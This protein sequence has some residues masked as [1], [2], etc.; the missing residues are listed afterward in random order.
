[1]APERGRQPWLLPVLLI[2]VIATAI[3]GLL[4][5]TVYEDREVADVVPAPSTSV[6]PEEQPGPTVVLGTQDAGAHPL[7][8]PVR[9]VL[10]TYFDAIN[11]RDYE[12]WTATVT[13][14][15]VD[16]QPREAWLRSY[17]STRDG[18]IVVHRIELAAEGEARVLMK[19]TSVQDPADAPQE[20]RVPC[21][22][23]NVVFPLVET[24]AGWKIDSG[25]TAASPQHEACA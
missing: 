4:A 23:W 7:F 25:T 14:N 20:L 10:Q 22:N 17:R 11:A 9:A 2:T 21:I 13:P 8:E 1:M 18:S 15:R 24:D 5:R 12:A 6:P 19:F 16:R 3:G